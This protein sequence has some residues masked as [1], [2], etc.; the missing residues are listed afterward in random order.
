MKSSRVKQMKHT[1][2]ALIFV[3]LFVGTNCNPCV[4]AAPVADFYV[5]PQGSDDWSG[6]LPDLNDQRNDG[7]FATLER[8]RDA[9]RELKKSKQSDIS[10][11]IRGG[12]YQLTQPVV[13]GTNDAPQGDSTITYGA[14][15]DETPV[16]SSGQEIKDWRKVTGDLPGLPSE[17][18]GK[19]WEADVSGQFRTLYDSEGML[20]RARST[21]FIPLQGGSRNK[22][23]FPKG[24]LR[25]WSNV[26]DVEII[27]RPH[28]AWIVNVLPLVSVDETAQ[29]ANTSI[30]ATYAMNRLHF[31]KDTESCWVENVLEELDT[32]G[33]WV[34]NTKQG[35]LYL[36]LR[37]KSP[38]VAPQLIEFIRVEG[39]IDKEGPHDSPV[40][41]LCFRGLSFMHGDR[42]L[43]S[44]DDAGLQHDWDMHDKANA[45]VRLRGTE[46]C[47]IEKCHF[48]HSGSGAIRVD[49]H[50]QQNRIVDNVIEHMGGAGVLLCGYGPGTKDVNKN[51]LVSNNHIHHT[52]QIYSH[53]PGIM[54]WQSGENR[55]ANNLVHHTP[56]TSI[57]VSGCMTDF[58]T[59]NGRELGRTIRRHEIVGLPKKPTLD[60]V[61]P[62]LHTRN[63]AIEYNEIHHAME[64]LGD[65][66]AIYIR[67]AG[68]GNVIRGNYV[69][70][71]VAPM[72]MQCAI[73]TDGGQMD[74]LIADN[75]IYKCTSQG[76]M[77]KLNTRCE[78]NI[79]ADI[80]AP[81][82]G[83][84]LAVREGPLTGATIKRN[85]FYSP[86]TTCT[87]ID[88]LPPGN[89]RVSEDRRG[90]ALANSKDAD[91]DY[92]V[93]YC[94]ADPS[95]ADTM[96]SKQ[97]ADGV[98]A[99]S[100][101]A[102]PLF[103][104]PENGDFR[105]QP[106]SPAIKL[107]IVPLDLSKVG[108][109]K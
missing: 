90:R 73:R 100:I 43:I 4:A 31:L 26:E 92:N 44:S 61:R 83:Y 106:N 60:D 39:D 74:T 56:Y 2:V 107:G 24:R 82:R 81:P 32:P 76:I 12:T 48:A 64:M 86:T 84:Y 80:I 51:N 17:A 10:V 21:G 96:L 72:I 40:R 49:L 99:H 19:V 52:G 8:A 65:G 71:M 57:I 11:L 13:F 87:F 35:K 69:H 58:F 1:I 38:V 93:Y 29:I 5:S 47:T 54:V 22:L 46:N 9:V 53:S 27:V 91:C 77:L 15:P 101:A 25:N 59:K 104:D 105:L 37:G 6:T 94:K 75:L 14:Y 108:L 42:Y 103:V 50:G 23:H 62:Y 3:V 85:I 18:I 30:D 95:L 20:P 41:N 63:N 66:N 36:W 33:E 98:D 97:Q 68:A 67:G 89:G 109:I 78:N 88:E 79:V 45:L 28:H 7:P 34:L 16:F 55:V 102:D 70:H